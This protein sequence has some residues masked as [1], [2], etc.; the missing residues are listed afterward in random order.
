MKT[1]HNYCLAKWI[2]ITYVHILRFKYNLTTICN[3]KRNSCASQDKFNYTTQDQRRVTE[4]NP[5]SSESSGKGAS[6]VPAV[7]P[8]GV[9]APFWNR[10]YDNRP[11]CVSGGHEGQD[12]VGTMD[13]LS[14]VTDPH[15][16]ADARPPKL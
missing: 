13:D 9:H 5:C 12:F 15:C 6:I 11:A 16:W 10:A 3:N 2:K 14:G 4:N 7:G 1:F 8:F